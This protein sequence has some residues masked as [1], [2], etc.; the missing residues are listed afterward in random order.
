MKQHVLALQEACRACHPQSFADWQTSRHSATYAQ[1][2]LDPTHNKAEQLAPDCLRCHGMFF[3]GYYRGPGN[4]R[5]D[6]R[7]LGAER[8]RQGHP[9]GDPVPGL[10]PSPHCRR[11]VSV[12]PSVCA[13]RARPTCRRTCCPSRPSFRVIALVKVSTD[14]RQRLCTQCHAPNAFR[15]LGFLGR[16][17]AVRGA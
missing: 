8:R 10:P 7:P 4:P 3:D 9:A 14:P 16:S 15:Q 17:H 12:G 5:L 6:H 1:V 2:F 13:A 11:R